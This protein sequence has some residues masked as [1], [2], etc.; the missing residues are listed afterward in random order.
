MAELLQLTPL[1]KGKT[2]GD[3]FFE[4]FRIMGSMSAEELKE[5]KQRV[6]FDSTLLD[7]FGVFKKI[8]LK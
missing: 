2:E 7:S 5:Y 3:Q 4:I 1:F 6:P 8:N